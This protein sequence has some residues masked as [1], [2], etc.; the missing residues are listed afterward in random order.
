MIYEFLVFYRDNADIW[1][2]LVEEMKAMSFLN[3][4][5]FAT[6]KHYTKR[7]K[8]FQQTALQEEEFVRYQSQIR[9]TFAILQDT[10]QEGMQQ[11]VFR[12]QNAEFLTCSL[13]SPLMLLAF[14]G[15]IKDPVQ[16]A[17]TF[18]ESFLH[19]LC[20]STPQL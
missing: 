6:A 11:G 14:A 16:D 3:K 5:F 13:F 18:T 8:S 9:Q 12:P 17:E 15:Y 2:I 19:G 7:N 4:N 1:I 20:T 10:L